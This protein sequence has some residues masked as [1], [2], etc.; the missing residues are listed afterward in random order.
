MLLTSA[1]SL[2]SVSSV[3][4]NGMDWQVLGSMKVPLEGVVGPGLGV[5]WGKGRHL[6]KSSIVWELRNATGR[7]V[8]ETCYL[9]EILRFCVV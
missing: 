9:Q 2:C 7:R 8:D 5:S 6:S 4:S 3:P 1:E